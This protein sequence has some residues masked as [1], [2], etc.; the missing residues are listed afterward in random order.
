MLQAHEGA[1]A[2]SFAGGPATTVGAS[3][4]IP[5]VCLRHSALLWCGGGPP[6]TLVSAKDQPSMP[7]LADG[8]VVNFAK[9]EQAPTFLRSEPSAPAAKVKKR[10][11]QRKT[12]NDKPDMEGRLD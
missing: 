12:K 3:R 6:L 1:A 7:F 11:W 2:Q 9:L 8:M 5:K 10:F 4:S